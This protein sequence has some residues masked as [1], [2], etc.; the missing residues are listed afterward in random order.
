MARV[1]EYSFL[2]GVAMR[3]RR[4]VFSDLFACF[5][6]CLCT[7]LLVL[8]NAPA[9]WAQSTSSGTVAGIVTDSSGA[10]VNGATVTLRDTS[11]NAS[12]V[13]TTNESGRYIFVDAAPGTYDL[14]VAKEGFST[15][16]TQTTVKVGVAITANLALQVGGTNVIV[17][18]TA[19]GNELQTMN[20]TVGKTIT[21]VALEPLPTFGRDVSTFLTM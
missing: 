16:K 10:V 19:A 8:I 11:T 6:L 9:V 14:S 12:R 18:V 1:G 20:S 4:D 13:I 15:S 3:I 21:G 5:L 2:E 7:T 17:E